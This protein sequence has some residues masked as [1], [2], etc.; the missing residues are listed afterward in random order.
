MDLIFRKFWATFERFY[1]EDDLRI[2]EELIEEDDILLY[3]WISGSVG[4]PEKYKVIIS[5]ITKEVSQK[6]SQ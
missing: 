3:K 6:T 2:F 4:V 5:R 1:T